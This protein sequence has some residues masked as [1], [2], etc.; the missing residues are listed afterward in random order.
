MTVLKKYNV[1][2]SQWEPIVTGVVGPTGPTGV[3]GP[4]GPTGVGATGATGPTGLTGA[5]GPTGDTGP[6]G[7]TGVAGPT[8]LTGSTGPTGVSATVAVGTTSG[9]ATGSV[10]NSGTSG[11][12]VFD[13]V[14]PIGATGA[15]G[16]TGATGPTGP[17]GPT[18]VTGPTGPTGATGAGAPLT[19]S[20]TAP[21]SPS[22]GDLWFNTTT[23]A[24]YIYYNSAWVELGGG[25]MSPMQVTSSTRPTSPWT[26]QTIFETDTGRNLQYS[27]SAWVEISSILTKAPR[28]VM[29]YNQ[30]TA[31]DL[32]I[33]TEEVQITGSTFSAVANR[34]YKV[35]YFEPQLYGSA[36][37][38]V[39]RIR[40]TNISGTQIQIS[41]PYIGG[42]I[43]V[44]NIVQWV[45]TLSAGNT[46]FVATL[47]SNSGT[48]QAYCA[49]NEIGF[50][51]VEDI[52]GA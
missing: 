6:T 31:S 27:G 51:L 28:G 44:P 5:T 11:A 45:G 33:T 2:T 38:M 52:G 23:G 36:T 1:A 50:L 32:T 19:S 34:Y 15:T 37:Y 24:S 16:T 39:S 17:T 20:A 41:Y 29:A 21:V 13:F 12:A 3:T 18:G 10:T 40:L 49:S 35:T 14:V 46:N 42:S 7:P 9:G 8:G 30:V 47:S 26:G 25:S 22:A 4:T 43:N 48:G